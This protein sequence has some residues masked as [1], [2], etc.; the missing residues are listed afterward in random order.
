M[1]FFEMFREEFGVSRTERLLEKIERVVPWEILEKEI[2][3][4]RENGK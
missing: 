3:S 4:K 2:W 1:N